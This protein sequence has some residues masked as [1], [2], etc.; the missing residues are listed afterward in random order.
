MSTHHDLK[1]T[2]TQQ[3]LAKM[4]KAVDALAGVKASL[5]AF[6][7]RKADDYLREGIRLLEQARFETDLAMLLQEHDDST[8]T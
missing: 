1:W 2:A 4:C 7:W 3:T 8:T 6:L 5:A